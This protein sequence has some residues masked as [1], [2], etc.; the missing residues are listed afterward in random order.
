MQPIFDCSLFRGITP[1]EIKEMFAL[2]N[3]SIKTCHKNAIIKFQGDEYADLLIILNGVISAEIQSPDGK[4]IIIETLRTSSVLASAVLFAS[5]NTLPVTITAD[6]DVK[7][8][9]LSRKTIIQFCRGNE[10]FLLN[11]LQD[12]G[13]KVIFLAEKIRLFKFKSIN[14]KIAGY[15]LNL[16]GKQG[17]DSVKITY[18]REQL[19]DLFGIARPSL[20]RSFSELYN[21]GILGRDGKIIHILDR[22][23]LKEIILNEDT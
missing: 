13:N 3:T 7:I 4:R 17:T 21:L 9:S 18:S 16:S 12:T 15:L 20:S 11:Y 5:D 19:A 14:Q 1:E 23:R 6:T 2:T 22:I 10:K 8:I